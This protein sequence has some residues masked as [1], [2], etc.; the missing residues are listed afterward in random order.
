METDALIQ[1]LARAPKVQGPPAAVWLAIALAATLAYSVLAI[2]IIAGA[3]PDFAA[4]APW[5][6]AKAGLSLLFALAAAP[7]LLRLSKPGHGAGAWLP[8][9]GVLA[10]GCA[11]TVAGSLASTADG[12]RMR[13]FTGGS[14]PVCAIVIPT[15]AT[16]SAAALFLWLRK[17]APTRPVLAGMAAGALSGALAAMAYAL[18]CPV[19]SAA[20]VATWYPVAIAACAAMGAL[21]GR[22]A[23][24]W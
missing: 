22:F 5:V 3:R 19:D 10:A 13:A 2:L 18:T 23:L 16:P 7:L 4:G 8:L 17:Q 12:E 20:F 9:L 24:R 21:A 6:A 11:M 1:T 14:F 15:L